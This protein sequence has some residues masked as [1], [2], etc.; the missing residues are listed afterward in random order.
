MKKFDADEKAKEGSLEVTMG[1][2]VFIAEEP[3][4]R[5]MKEMANRIPDA[6]KPEKDADGKVIPRSEKEELEESV[7]SL[8]PQL[9]VLLAA[10]EA[11]EYEREVEEE[12]SDKPKKKKV[13]V[14]EGDPPPQDYVEKHLSMRRAGEMIQE[15]M[16][17]DANDPR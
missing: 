13:K 15:L 4:L 16:G 10:K 14:A 9:E 17:E 2:H 7:E 6:P 3:T 12:G 5:T 11:F 8:Y 1:G